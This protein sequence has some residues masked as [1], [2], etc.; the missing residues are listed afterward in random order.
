MVTNVEKSKRAQ[1]KCAKGYSY[2]AGKITASVM[3]SVCSTSVTQPSISLLKKN[4][5][6]EQNTFTSAATAW[7]LEHEDDAV[8]S[9]VDVMVKNHTDFTHRKTGVYLSTQHPYTAASPDS[10]VCCACC[11]KGV[12]EVKCP[13]SLAINTIQNA[14]N[15]SDFCLE[16]VDGNLRLKRKHPFFYQV[17]TQMAVCGVTYADFVVWSPLSKPHIERVLKDDAFFDSVIRT[18]IDFF[19]CAILPELFSQYFTRKC[20]PKSKASMNSFC[21][22]QGPEAGKMLACDMAN[23]A[24]TVGS[25]TVA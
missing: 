20:T 18:A 10:L 14:V 22:C 9:Y 4:C 19:R 8:S 3:K 5:Y 15:D 7:S 12:V 1:S 24:N 13:H 2:R 25:I 16:D 11:G 21:Y 6:P 23:T 17:Q